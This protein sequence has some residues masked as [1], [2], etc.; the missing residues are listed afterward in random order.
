ML[1]RPVFA[2][3][4]PKVEPI[5]EPRPSTAGSF[6]MT[7]SISRWRRHISWGEMS[8]APSDMPAMRP[9][10]WIGK[11]PFGIWYIMT[12]VRAMVAKNTASVIA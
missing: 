9:M 7:S 12:P 5:C 6:K 11:K 3:C 8:W 2:V 1:K 4:A 10:S